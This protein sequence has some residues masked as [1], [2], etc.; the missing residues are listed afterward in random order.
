M[1]SIPNVSPS[2]LD[3]IKRKAKAIGRERQLARYVALDISARQSGYESYQHARKAI[4]R[5]QQPTSLHS[6]FL[7]AYWRDMSTV[8]RTSGLE[9]LELRLPRS[10]TSFLSKHQC[11]F[12]RNLGGFF[13]EYSDHLEMRG[14]AG[15]QTRARELLTRAALALRFVE[16]TGL[17]PATTK[18]QRKMF[19]KAENLPSCDHVSRWI[20]PDTGSWLMLD[21]PYSH[22]TQPAA[23]AERESWIATSALCWAKP[24]WE[25]L[26]YPGQAV[27]YLV[28]KDGELLERVKGIVERTAKQTLVGAEGFLPSEAFHSQFV[29]PAREM[30]GKKRKPR[31]GTTYGYSKNAVEYRRQEGYAVYW[32]PAHRMSVENHLEMGR[33][34]KRLY[35]SKTPHV[36]HSNLSNLRSEL[37]DWMFA[38]YCFEERDGV[39][40]S[41]YYGGDSIAPYPNLAEIIA[42]V[43]HV[44]SIMVSTYQD[45]KPLRTYLKK[46]DA[47]RQQ[48]SNAPS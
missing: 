2:T 13:A 48:I 32:R 36:A 3:G 23:H 47:A 40:L 20:C 22:V 35:V 16:A 43:D 4:R 11:S 26:Y 10:L 14:N 34:L 7:S 39:D 12:A 1:S 42:A 41:A 24:D 25:G 15:S 38:E 6:I 8:P 29:S 45:S 21:E 18:L 27:P 31:L 17:L 19:E 37:E 44:R 9:I 30:D 33:T 5:D 28:A 46:L